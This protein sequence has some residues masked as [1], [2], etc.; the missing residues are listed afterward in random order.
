MKARRAHRCRLAVTLTLAMALGG[1]ATAPPEASAPW[2]HAEVNRRLPPGAASTEPPAPLSDTALREALAQ[3][4]DADAAVRLALRQHP[5][6]HAR[7]HRL[8]V[9]EAEAWQALQ[10][11][12]PGLSLG[13]LSQGGA[14]SWE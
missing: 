5:S 10:W 9:A 7:L 1:C 4:L 14:L 12:N 3:P 6:V 8:G 2:V 11:P 13:R